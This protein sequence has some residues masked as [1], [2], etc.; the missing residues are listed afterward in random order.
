MIFN[1]ERVDIKRNGWEMK[2]TGEA[3]EEAIIGPEVPDGRGLDNFNPLRD[4]L[5]FMVQSLLGIMGLILV[6]GGPF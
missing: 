2:V 1:C 4:Q 6:V 5:D 3:G